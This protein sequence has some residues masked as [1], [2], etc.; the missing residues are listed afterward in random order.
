MND[1]KV[2]IESGHPRIIALANNT[3][4]S[5]TWSREG[6][7]YPSTLGGVVELAWQKLE[8]MDNYYVDNGSTPI[9]VGFGIGYKQFTALGSSNDTCWSYRDPLE[10]T[11][12][13][14]NKLMFEL[15]S[16]TGIGKN[17]VGKDGNRSPM[18]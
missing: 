7:E 6:L 12:S 5:H 9:G 14:L 18:P 11:I 15:G 1:E 16:S 17:A 10:D 13:D 4:V 2:E 3:E 8:T